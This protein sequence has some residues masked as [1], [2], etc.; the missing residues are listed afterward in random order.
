MEID[1]D[2][3]VRAFCLLRGGIVIVASLHIE[4]VIKRNGVE[5]QEWWLWSLQ[6]E[7]SAIVK[8]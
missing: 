1:L 5:L 2:M 7:L 8:L 6:G 3:L 4:T